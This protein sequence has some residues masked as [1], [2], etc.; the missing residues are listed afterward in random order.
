MKAPLFETVLLLLLASNLSFGQ[1]VDSKDASR[2]NIAVLGVLDE[3]ER[4]CTF[5]EKN[6]RRD[7]LRLF[8]EKDDPCIYND[9]LGTAR[10]QALISPEAYSSPSGKDGSFLIRSSISD[11]RK[12]GGITYSDGKLHRRISFTKYVMIIDATVYS[13]SQGGVLFDSSQSYESSPDFRLY[14]TPSP[15]TAGSKRSGRRKRSRPPRWMTRD[16]PSSSPRTKNT[17]RIS[18]PG[19]KS[20]SSTSSARR[21]PIRTTS[22]STTA[23]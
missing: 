8:L 5:S 14:M 12:E 13:G 17:T 10:Y 22:T 15:E 21:S 7:F 16:S 11:V 3:Y 4:T 9:L 19:A 18:P 2:F 23:M 1:V 20:C 6:D